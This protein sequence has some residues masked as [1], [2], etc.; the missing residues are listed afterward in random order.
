MEPVDILAIGAHADDIEIGMGGTIAKWASRKKKIVLCDLT[1]GELSSNGSVGIRKKEAEEAAGVLGVM[2]R[3]NLG[4]PDR[5]IQNSQEQIKAVVD[6]I[7]KYQP[8]IIFAPYF[9]DR[10]PDHGNASSLVKEAAF[11]AGIRKFN[12]DA[13][14]ICKAPVYY[15]MIN[16][17]HTPDFAADIS[18][19]IEKKKTALAAYKSQFQPAG[20]VSTPLTEGYVDSVIARDLLTGKQAGCLY[21][22]GFMTDHLILLDHDLLG[23]F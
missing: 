10:H 8:K 3:I 11:S 1:A 14:P 12:P 19:E 21:A 6:V 23:E 15:Y 7:R 9:E 22:E 17:I 5:G 4:I 20:G 13:A 16:G 2:E 18:A